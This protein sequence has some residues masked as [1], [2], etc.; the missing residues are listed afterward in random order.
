MW[1]YYC[2]SQNTNFWLKLGRLTETLH[3]ACQT[4]GPQGFRVWPHS[5][6]IHEVWLSYWKTTANIIAGYWKPCCLSKICLLITLF[7]VYVLCLCIIINP[8]VFFI[9]IWHYHQQK[10][11]LDGSS[12]KNTHEEHFVLFYLSLLKIYKWWVVRECDMLW[13]EM[14]S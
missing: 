8:E 7:Y 13:H 10:A 14:S 5:P 4:H 3:Q 1:S 9:F 11:G 12:G 2:Y 6:C